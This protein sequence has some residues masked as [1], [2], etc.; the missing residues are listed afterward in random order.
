MEQRQRILAKVRGLLA[1]A[2]STD[3]PDEAAVYTTKAQELIARYAIDVALIEEREGRGKIVTRLIEIS[4]PYPKEKFILLGRVARANNARALL[5]IERYRLKEMIDD[6]SLF[7]YDG[8]IAT[9]VGYESD[10]DA[11]ELLFTSLLVQ[12]VNEMLTHG[13]QVTEW[14]ENRTRSFRRSFLNQF[15]WTVGGRLEEA[16][17]R[18]RADAS[19]MH[20]DSL[21][22]VLADREEMVQSEVERRFPHATPLRTSVSNVDGVLAGRDAGRRADIGSTRLRGRQPSLGA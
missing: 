8:K 20:G 3:Y 17:E 4:T 12:A 21:L 1:K 18:A 10:L 15:A 9:V 14:G 6:R 7:D 11:I 5:G 16:R 2:E 22:P 13:S 19:S